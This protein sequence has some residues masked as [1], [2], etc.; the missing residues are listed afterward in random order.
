MPED[1]W[2]NI[3]WQVIIHYLR[4]HVTMFWLAYR[5]TSKHTFPSHHLLILLNSAKGKT[6]ITALNI[7]Y[8]YYIF[9]NLICTQFWPFLKWE[10]VHSQFKFS[11]FFQPSLAHEATDWI[12]LNIITIT[13]AL[14]S[15]AMPGASESYRYRTAGLSQQACAVSSEISSCLGCWRCLFWFVVCHNYVR[16]MPQI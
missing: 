15:Y 12:I 10:N 14:K 6:F 5:L 13:S 7:N 1:T 2:N 4:T 8:R 3:S 11:L 9:F 16:G